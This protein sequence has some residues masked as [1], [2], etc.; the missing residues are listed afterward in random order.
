[1]AK[2]LSDAKRQYY[3]WDEF[4]ID[5]SKIVDFASW[6]LK[7][8][9][10]DGIYGV[11]RGGLILAVCLSHRLKLPLLATPTKYTLIVDDI[12]DSG[13]TLLCYKKTRNCII[14]L[15][16]HPQSKVNPDIWIRAKKDRW[17]DFPWEVI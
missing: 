1:M 2:K 11:P 17:I 12:A 7:N 9:Y 6:Q 3:S 16:K 8:A 14:T 13:T 10:L 5:V 15:F 4:R